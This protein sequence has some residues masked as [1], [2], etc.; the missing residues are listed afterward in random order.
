MIKG[1]VFDFGGV[2]TTMTMPER[3]KPLVAELGVPWSAL[4][5]GFAKY[6][7]QMDGDLMTMDEMYDRILADAGLALDPA[8][9]ARIIAED[10]ASFLYRNEATRDWMASLRA[11]GFKV[12]ILTNMCTDFARRF[13]V[14]FADFIALADAVVISGEERLYKPQPEIYARLRETLSKRE[15]EVLGLYVDGLSYSSIAER[16]GI[17]TKAVDN[18]LQRVRRKV[19]GFDMS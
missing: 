5:A 13:R 10:Q 11:R 9:R 8:V 18:A 12:G 1:V 15:F 19:S 4:E 7:R 14:T 2:M 16:L 17:T 3:V 6:R